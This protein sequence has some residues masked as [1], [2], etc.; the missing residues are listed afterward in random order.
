MRLNVFRRLAVKAAAGVFIF[1]GLMVMHP[2]DSM[3]AARTEVQTRSSYMV[4]IEA[5]SVDVYTYKSKGAETIGEVKRGQTYE[6]LEKGRDGWVQIRMGSRKGYIPASGNAT[7]VEK[8]CQTVDSGA[9]QRRE[10]VEFALQFLGGEYKYGGTDPNKGVDCSGFTRY[11]MKHGASVEIPHSSTGQ[12]GFGR[13]ISE[14]EMQ[15]GD[16]IF[17]GNSFGR[18]NHVAMY[19]GDGQVVHA[20]T[21]KTGIK[22]SPYNYRKP[23]KIVSVLQ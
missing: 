10:L 13:E 8:N 23:V 5:P 21:E 15:Q 22:L 1:A 19:A 16:L 11:V 12:A 14:E 4:T 9:R 7:L 18:I 17:Y 3:A 2:Q 6:V 20:S